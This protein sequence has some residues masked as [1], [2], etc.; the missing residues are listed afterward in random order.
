MFVIFADGNGLLFVSPLLDLNETITITYFQNLLDIF[1]EVLKVF[2]F[3]QLQ[4][5]L[6]IAICSKQIKST[7]LVDI[8]A[9]VLSLENDWSWDHITSAESLFVLLV[10]E[11]VLTSNHGLGGTVLAWLVSGER[12]DFAWEFTLHHEES[13]WL[14]ATGFDQ[15]DVARASVTHDELIF[16]VKHSL[17]L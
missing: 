12:Y 3:G 14:S 8:N 9:D 16:F 6:R 5:I 1:L 13:A 7:I 2:F 17:I 11:D 15:L 10:G 4:V